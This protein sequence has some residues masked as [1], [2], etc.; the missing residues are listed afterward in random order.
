RE[1]AARDVLQGALVRR[2]GAVDEQNEGERQHL[3]RD[4]KTPSFLESEARRD[5]QDASRQRRRG[6]AEQRI[7]QVVDGI[8][9]VGRVEGVERL[10]PELQ[11]G[12]LAAQPGRVDRLDQREVDVEIARPAEG[13][14]AQAARLS[15][16]GRREVR[17]GED[18]VQEVVV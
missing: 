16:R 17:G 14:A 7:G 4:L 8:E 5:L 9:Q 15:E 2:L 6:L 3:V 1:F 11:L 18:P 13:V 10:Q 12:A